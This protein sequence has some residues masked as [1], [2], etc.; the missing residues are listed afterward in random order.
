M[1]VI[2]SGVDVTFIAQE[3]NSIPTVYTES[4][5]ITSQ[6]CMAQYGDDARGTPPLNHAGH[7]PT[8][9]LRRVGA[10]ETCTLGE[11]TYM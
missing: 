11:E 5:Y 7:V 6:S 10:L 9:K 2:D 8:L 1:I 3:L 4:H